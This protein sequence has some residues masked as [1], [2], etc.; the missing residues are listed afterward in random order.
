MSLTVREKH[1]LTRKLPL[2]P[3]GDSEGFLLVDN[4]NAKLFDSK[5]VKKMLP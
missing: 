3:S 5:R 4:K 2:F 1:C